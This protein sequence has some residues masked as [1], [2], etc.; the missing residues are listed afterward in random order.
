LG[1]NWANEKSWFR[2]GASVCHSL[3]TESEADEYLLRKLNSRS[4]MY[5]AACL[6]SL[7]DKVERDLGKIKLNQGAGDACIVDRLVLT[8]HFLSETFAGIALEAKGRDAVAIN[9]CDLASRSPTENMTYKSLE[10]DWYDKLCP[11]V[12]R[13][14]DSAVSQG[15]DDELLI[16]YTAYCTPVS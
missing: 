9:L 11:H 15:D 7:D 4:G 16:Q 8:E 5:A 3:A 14:I 10:A 2:A 1:N 12:L 13:L 6:L